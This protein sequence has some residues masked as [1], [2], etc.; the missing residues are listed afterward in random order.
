MLQNPQNPFGKVVDYFYKVTFQM[1]GSHIHM[2]VWADDAPV[3]EDSEEST[4]EVISFVDEHV[5]CRMEEDI[6]E[7]VAVQQH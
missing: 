1:R 7:L 4:A 6:E 2:L 5:T 3:S